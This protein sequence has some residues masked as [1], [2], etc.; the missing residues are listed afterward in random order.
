MVVLI[1]S[2]ISHWCWN[3]QPWVSNGE[4]RPLHPMERREVTREGR[5][6]LAPVASD[7]VEDARVQGVAN[8]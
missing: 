8:R 6:P 7:L 5:V 2:S 3:G 1:V 4:K